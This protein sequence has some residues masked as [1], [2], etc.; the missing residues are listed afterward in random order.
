MHL[1]VALLQEEDAQSTELLQDLFKAQPMQLPPQS[2]SDSE[3]SL[4]PLK[5][6][7]VLLTALGVCTAA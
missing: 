6:G 3:P 2:T 7:A 5:Q 1:R 4:M